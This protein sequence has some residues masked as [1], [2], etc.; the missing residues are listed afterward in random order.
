MSFRLRGLV[1]QITDLKMKTAA[2]RLAV[3]LAGLAEAESGPAEIRLPYG[4]KLLASQLGMQPETLSRAF[5]KL[6]ALGV[7]C[8]VS[9]NF[10]RIRDMA[11]LRE[12]SEDAEENA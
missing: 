11:V 7:R 2:Q 12:F 10:L 4:K 8:V 3:H 9:E 1:R 6:Q 5:L